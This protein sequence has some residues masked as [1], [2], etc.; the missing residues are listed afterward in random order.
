MRPDERVHQQHRG[1]EGRRGANEVD[2]KGYGMLAKM[3]W[4]DGDGLGKTGQGRAEPVQVE[5]RMERAGLG[6]N[7]AS[8]QASKGSQ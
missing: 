5:Q 7:A 1:H 6:S 2:N 3:G 4:K 8:V